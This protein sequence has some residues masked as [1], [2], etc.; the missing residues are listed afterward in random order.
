[1][2]QPGRQA[3]R[4]GTGPTG[5]PPTA[6]PEADRLP[7]A[8]R[9]AVSG[10]PYFGRRMAELLAS[11]GWEAAYLETRR[12]QPG[13][14]LRAVRQAR[15]ADVLYQVGGQI[16]RWS[17]PH[18]LLTVVRR[19]CVMHWTGSDVLYA[20]TVAARGR[21]AER[22]RG[23]CIHWAGAPWLAGEL[24][25]IGVRAEWVPHSAVEAPEQLPAFPDTFTVLAYLRAGRE[26]FY[27]EEA[28]R[29]VAVAL[30]DVRVLVAGCDRLA[31]PSPPNVR[32]LGWVQDIASVYARAH[33]LLRM[34]A[35]DGLS[36]MVQEALAFGRYAVWNHPFPG[37]L[38]AATDEEAR[39]HIA[40]FAAR[41]RA[42]S[43]ALNV[44]GARHVRERYNPQ[45]IRD[46]I[47]RRLAAII[48]ARR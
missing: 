20:R 21:V 5:T 27:G 29:R 19:P 38:E 39:A 44:A 4:L 18:A 45:R 46:D 23:G 22:L 16:A 31:G 17:R 47:R 28:V 30:P 32:C 2:P 9:L 37:V 35:H 26:A 41:H 6:P 7:T 10:L 33:V 34:A 15:R 3:Q 1:M 40:D 48:E 42:G 13:P 11:D 8:H 25:G 12:W 14:A 36:F 43:L 24:A